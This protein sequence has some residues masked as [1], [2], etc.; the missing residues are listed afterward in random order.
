MQY[1]SILIPLVLLSLA[2]PSALW[3]QKNKLLVCL[4]EEETQ[5]HKR[6]INGPIYKLNQHFINELAG[7]NDV[8]LKDEFY[9]EICKKKILSPSV[10]LLYHLLLQGK[11][12]F[13]IPSRSTKNVGL[14]QFKIALLGN[15][16]R[17][18]PHIMFNYLSS[19]QALAPTPDCL[20]KHVPNL[21]YYLERYKYLESGS[22][23]G[24]LINDKEKIKELFAGLK[25]LDSILLKCKRTA[26]RERKKRSGG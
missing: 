17:S 2:F 12:I 19:L 11:S 16:Q 26:I 25:K 21:A 18:V 7:I 9:Q 10:N 8:P 14:R 5:I 15:L 20:F 22:Q 13:K 4:G 6:K 23:S 1:N 3:A 24:N